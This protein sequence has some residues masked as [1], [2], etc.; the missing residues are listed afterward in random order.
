MSTASDKSRCL[1]F[2]FPMP[3]RPPCSLSLPCRSSSIG[4]HTSLLCRPQ[5][6]LSSLRG[7]R[8]D[9]NLLGLVEVEHGGR[10]LAPHARRGGAGQFGGTLVTTLGPVYRC[11]WFLHAAGKENRTLSSWTLL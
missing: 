3:S 9:F 7:L 5:A 4:R 8:E 2:G 6:L 1:C 11:R 10:T